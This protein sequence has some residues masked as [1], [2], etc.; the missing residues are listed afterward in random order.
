V[1]EDLITDQKFPMS[2]SR[3]SRKAHE[4][5]TKWMLNRRNSFLGAQ[6]NRLE[7]AE[8]VVEIRGKDG[9]AD[10]VWATPEQVRRLSDALKGLRYTQ[11]DLELGRFLIPPAWSGGWARTLDWDDPRV[12]AILDKHKLSEDYKSRFQNFWDIQPWTHT[13]YFI[14]TSE[15]GLANH[16]L[17][18]DQVVAE[19]R[20][21]FSKKEQ[22]PQEAPALEG[23]PK[24]AR[25]RYPNVMDVAMTQHLS[26]DAA[27]IH[28]PYKFYY[29]DP[30]IDAVAKTFGLKR[31]ALAGA[32]G[33]YWHYQAVGEPLHGSQPNEERRAE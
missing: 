23:Y 2:G 28:F 11:A 19:I 9:V 27:D 4:L 13:E 5:S 8:K 7:F 6:A 17:T 33:E 1:Q 21:H 15:R 18:I 24:G 10:I 3:T 26:G 16:R 14:R 25:E 29:F 32:H 31:V 22:G 20:D 30:I 12:Q